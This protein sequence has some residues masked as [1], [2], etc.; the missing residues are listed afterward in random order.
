MFRIYV[1]RQR[2]KRW[3]FL[4]R[5]QP[6]GQPLVELARNNTNS[7]WRNECGCA[8]SEDCGGIRGTIRES[9]S[10][11]FGMFSCSQESVVSRGG[12]GGG[13]GECPFPSFMPGLTYAIYGG[14]WCWENRP[15][16][17]KEQVRTSAWNLVGR[18]VKITSAFPPRC[19][20]ASYMYTA[21]TVTNLA[22]FL[23]MLLSSRLV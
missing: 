11:L 4:V 19:T 2:R 8:R 22:F 15:S 16:F 9:R 5:R 23:L 10:S 3:Y 17:E 20:R 1:G 7:P 21:C 6:R 13:G 12:G 18:S 14:Q